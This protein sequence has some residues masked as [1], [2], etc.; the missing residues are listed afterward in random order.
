MFEKKLIAICDICGKTID[1]KMVVTGGVSLWET[2]LGWK[3]V[4][5]TRGN[6]DLK[7][8][9]EKLACDLHLLQFTNGTEAPTVIL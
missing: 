9:V 3:R 2:P 4:T 5:A 8:Q 6:P 1:A 7:Q